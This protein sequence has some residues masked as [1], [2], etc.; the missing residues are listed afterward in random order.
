MRL[1]LIIVVL[2][3]PLLSAPA[4]AADPPAQLRAFWVDAFNSG[5][6]NEDQVRQLVDDALAA[7]ANALIVQVR[8]RGDSYYVGGVEPRTQD[9]ALAPAPY[10]PLGT[11]L[12]EAH[13][14]GLQV[15]AWIATLVVWQTS[16]GTPPDGHVLQA[17]GPGA[18]D[19]DDWVMRDAAG[20]TADGENLI[21]L[22]PGH[23][24][25]VDYTETVVRDLL[26]R[27][28][29]LDGL[30]LDRIRYPGAGFGYNP[31][32]V[33]RF[34]A[35]YGRT[36]TPFASDPLWAGW[37]R[38]QVTALVRRLALA[39]AEV[40]P[41]ARLSAAA[42]AWGDGPD[43]VGGWE[44]SAPYN[45]VLQ[46]WR[47]W[48][49]ESL[50]DTAIVMNYDREHV[51]AQ[52]DYFDHWLAWETSE[53][54]GEVVVGVAAYLNRV[55][56]TLAQVARAQASGAAG[57]ALYSYAGTNGEAQP[58][59]AVLAALAGGPFA[60]PA[61]VPPMPWKEDRGALAGTLDG[62]PELQATEGVSITLD[63]P[64][65]REVASDGAGWFGATRL[66]PGQYTALVMLGDRQIAR[67]QAQVAAG[68]TV[69]VEQWE[70]VDLS[71]NVYLAH[72]AVAGE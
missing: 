21:W 52:R 22:D 35:R 68:E 17:H 30:H 48:L 67:A 36:G 41:R 4:Q 10:D 13:A 53:A 2:L 57:V 56:G 7:N 54:G 72:I 33:A 31:T 66:E 23:P 3:A 50:I 65:R 46:D 42:I 27:Y 34:N 71:R 16:M 12:N 24:Q 25:V 58:R 45:Q 18:P 15:H 9:P 38:A 43:H 39:A 37:R 40:T 29:D 59:S 32:A 20:A 47:G 51:N 8:R 70:A 6:K 49:R 62:L 14:R 60:A 28:P 1:L 5:I 64:D 26:A 55:D 69:R 19:A 63:G 11:L 44:N 61:V